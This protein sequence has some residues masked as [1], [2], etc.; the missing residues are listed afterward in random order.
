LR[1]ITPYAII[2]AWRAAV[3]DIEGFRSALDGET[4][5]M[6][7]RLREIVASSHPSLIE[8]I[9]WNAPSFAVGGDDRITL[10]VERKGGVRLVLHRGAKLRP[11]EGFSFDDTA[12]LAKWPAADRGVMIWKDVAS[13]DRVASQLK[14]ICRRWIEQV[15]DDN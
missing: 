10:G 14:L 7:D 8:Q 3:Q 5:A 6:I 13:I 4:L 9:K 12:Q 2:L 11:A 1:K 15:G